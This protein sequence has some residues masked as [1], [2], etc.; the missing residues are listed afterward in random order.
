MKRTYS[1]M[2]NLDQ[3][4]IKFEINSKDDKNDSTNDHLN[5]DTISE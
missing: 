1:A 5:S 2:E 4:Q 3:A